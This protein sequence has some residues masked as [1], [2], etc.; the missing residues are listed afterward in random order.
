MDQPQPQPQPPTPTSLGQDKVPTPHPT[1][2]RDPTVAD[3]ATSLFLP[4][5]VHHTPHQGTSR[6]PA[7]DPTLRRLLVTDRVPTLVHPRTHPPDTNQAPAPAPAPTRAARDIPQGPH[8]TALTKDPPTTSL[9]T[10]VT[11]GVN[12]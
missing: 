6:V 8:H 10:R 4:P 12:L 5:R 11:D 9:H 3:P 2:S 1:T 7:E